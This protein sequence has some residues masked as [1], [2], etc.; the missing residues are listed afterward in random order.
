MVAEANET[1]QGA[2]GGEASRRRPCSVVAKAQGEDP[3]GTAWAAERL[4]LVEVPLPWP[5][6]YREARGLPPGLADMITGM[7]ETH[8]NAGLLTIAPDRDLSR[9]GLLR[10]IDFAC[11]APPRTGMVRSE[12]LVPADS[13]AAFVAA[14]LSDD[15]RP[16]SAMPGVEPQAFAGRD[17]L[18]CT[19]GTIDA[20]CALFG[21]PSYRRL[22]ASARASGDEVRVWRSSH[23][24]G[25][26]FAPT[27][28]EL[29][30]GRF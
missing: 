25:H 30:S 22:R 16:A 5:Y 24:G 26:R 27:V 3:I 13:V 28:L 9:D 14:R 6:D 12:F 29:P 7:W 4:L 18:I 11:P 2:V 20:C 15:P 21:Y 23:F 19:H 17:L 8:P 1:E 10:V